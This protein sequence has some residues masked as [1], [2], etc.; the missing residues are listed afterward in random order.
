M[1]ASALSSN[2]TVS[3]S[4]GGPFGV[5]FCARAQS[6]A[7]PPLPLDQTKICAAAGGVQEAITTTSSIQTL[8]TQP[9]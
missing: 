1:L 5:Q 8:H 2:W 6:F 9:V 3:L 4:E 7:L